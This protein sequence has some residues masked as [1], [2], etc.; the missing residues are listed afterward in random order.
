MSVSWEYS[1]KISVMYMGYLIQYKAFQSGTKFTLQA[2]LGRFFLLLREQQMFEAA[3]K[4]SSKF[5]AFYT[6]LKFHSLSHL[7]YLLLACVRLMFMVIT[8]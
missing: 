3:V 7:L 8:I 4:V 2:E 5:S 6:V 1:H